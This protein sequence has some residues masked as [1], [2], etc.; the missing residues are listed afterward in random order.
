MSGK[1]GLGREDSQGLWATVENSGGMEK[2]F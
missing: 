1:V 2:T